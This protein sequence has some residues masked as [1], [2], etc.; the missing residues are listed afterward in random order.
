[1]GTKLI[2]LNSLVLSENNLQIKDIDSL[3]MF[4]TVVLFIEN[5]D[6]SNN[7]LFLNELIILE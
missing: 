2:S 5:I 6:F 7:P 3:F 1:M 4:F